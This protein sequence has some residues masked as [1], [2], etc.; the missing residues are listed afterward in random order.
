MKR[1]KTVNGY[2]IYEAT[3][4]RDEADYNCG[5]GHYNLYLGSDIHDFGLSN[6]YPDYEDIE[7]MS[8]AIALANGSQFAV[9]T[10]MAW[11]LCDS[12]VEDTALRDEIE[13]RLEAGQPMDYIRDHYDTENGCFILDWMD[14]QPEQDIHTETG[15]TFEQFQKLAMANYANGGDVVVECWDEAAFEERVRMFGPMTKRAAFDLFALY[16]GAE[17]DALCWV[18]TLP[19]EEQACDFCSDEEKMADFAVMSKEA[20]LSSYSYLTEEEYDLT[21]AKV[22]PPTAELLAV[23]D[24]VLEE[25][26]SVDFGGP[27]H[28]G[29]TVREFIESTGDHP[30][31][32]DE[33]NAMLRCCG[34]LPVAQDIHTDA[35]PEQVMP[36]D[37]PEDSIGL[38]LYELEAIQPGDYLLEPDG[39]H[40]VRVLSADW[41]GTY[42]SFEVEDPRGN[43]SHIGAL[44]ANRATS[45][46]ASSDL[47]LRRRA[48]DA[49][50]KLA[51]KPFDLPVETSETKSLDRGGAQPVNVEY[52]DGSEGWEQPRYT[53]YYEGE[54]FFE[55]HYKRGGVGI[56]RN[57]HSRDDAFR[58][59]DYC[60]AHSIPVWVA[61]NHYGATYHGGEW[62]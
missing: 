55:D 12:T 10:A 11:E 24:T 2:A 6:S 21:A 1:I 18:D 58:L 32:I 8:E 44:H 59:S 43:R 38:M 46:A 29:E 25:D 19:V 41:S 51:P 14:T 9:A 7:T 33:L 34:I 23:M 56:H 62:N 52:S 37:M 26:Y 39:E 48:A 4:A 57:Y 45:V 42:P 31:T 53:V 13:R 47:G 28:M 54:V 3:S 30:T 16:R 60:E 5:I 17:A 50:A 40:I 27:D 20:F 22:A 36:E 35:Q 15:L 61:D 49:W